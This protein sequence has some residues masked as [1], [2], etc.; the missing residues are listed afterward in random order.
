MHKK[1][2][3]L[4]GVFMA[5]VMLFSTSI[6]AFAAEPSETETTGTISVEGIEEFFS[7]NADGT[8]SLN[9]LGAQNAGY[10]DDT[11]QFVLE[12][13][14][15][16]NE[17][18]RTEGAYIND[19]FAITFYF[20]VSRAAKGQSKV[21]FW[22]TG[23][24]LIYMNTEEI[25]ELYYFIDDLGWVGTALGVISLLSVAKP[26]MSQACALSST[27]AAIQLSLYKSQI[28]QVKQ[29][30]TGIIIYVAPTPDLIGNYITFGAQ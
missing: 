2:K 11:I 6:V 29:N 14:E 30:G 13:I 21:E 10:S 23:M 22:A 9:V 17:A 19:D 4:I 16:M 8:M 27:F 26:I 24:M 7:K 15:F 25:D 1:V 12:N 3:K 18:V 5:G 20:A 28:R